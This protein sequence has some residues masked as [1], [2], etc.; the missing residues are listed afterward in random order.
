MQHAGQA[1]SGET[2]APQSAAGRKAPTPLYYADMAKLQ[3]KEGQGGSG[4]TTPSWDLGV[5]AC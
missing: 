2:C 5:W 3:G 4:Y 1:G